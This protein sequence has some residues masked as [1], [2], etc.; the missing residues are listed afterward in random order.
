MKKT[1]CF[2]LGSL[3]GAYA[4]KEAFDGMANMLTAR[5]RMYYEI[6]TGKDEI[7]TAGT[8]LSKEPNEA[9]TSE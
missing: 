4:M 3:V 8:P 9:E 5:G 7:V 2:I 1:T 6:R